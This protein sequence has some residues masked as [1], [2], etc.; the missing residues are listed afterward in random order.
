MSEMEIQIL[1]DLHLEDP[2]EYDTFRIEAKAPYMALLGDIGNVCD[3]GFFD[4]IRKQLN[5]FQIVFLVFGN[6]EAHHSSWPKVKSQTREFERHVNQLYKSGM[7]FGN[8]VLL[9]E[10]RYDLSSKV[11]IL[12]CTLFTRVNN[13]ETTRIK[14]SLRDFYIIDRWSIDLHKKTHNSNLEW[15]NHQVEQISHNEPERIIA[16]LTHHCPSTQKNVTDP[17]HAE[18]TISAGYMSD[19]SHE[20]CWQNCSVRLWAF[21]HTHYNCDFRDMDT[22]K[23]IISNQRGYQFGKSKGFDRSKVIRF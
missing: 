20:P 12:G 6:H 2:E 17:S 14:H 23:R 15:L 16:I 21:G 8:F 9:D 19:L 13:E 22:G 10:N 4:F 3:R 1:S 5:I 7:I 18:S 11:T